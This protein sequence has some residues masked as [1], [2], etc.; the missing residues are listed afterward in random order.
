MTGG[1]RTLPLVNSIVTLQV[2][3]LLAPL[4]MITPIFAPS[5]MRPWICH[6]IQSLVMYMFLTFWH[7]KPYVLIWFVLIKKKR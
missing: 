7:L 5:K 3:H 4:I 2:P 1:Y 6:C